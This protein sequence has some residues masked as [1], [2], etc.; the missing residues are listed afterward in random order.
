MP[1][2]PFQS[3]SSAVTRSALIEALTYI[4]TSEAGSGEISRAVAQLDYLA[5]RT[6]VRTAP[7]RFHVAR[8]VAA[9]RAVSRMRYR[10]VLERGWGHA[11]DFPDGV[12]RDEFDDT[13][14]QI[15][16]VDGDRLVASGRIVLPDVERPLP[17]E[18]AFDLQIEPRGRVADW[19]RTIVAQEYTN[20]S[21]I[22]L[23]GLL[24][25]SWIETR[26]RGLS[27]VCGI[28]S[29]GMIR[30]YRALGLYFSVFASPRRY[31]S[32]ERVAVRFDALESARALLRLGQP[33]SAAVESS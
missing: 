3:S 20:S 16:G 23:A 18:K 6:V 21:H 1:A 33:K 17:T 15:T 24:A 13:A 11:A 28:F 32:V 9:R 22:V 7:V 12:E 29:P 14:V 10:V 5:H 30:L 27:D 4:R 31:W 2:F 19:S 25:Q 8:T 26:R